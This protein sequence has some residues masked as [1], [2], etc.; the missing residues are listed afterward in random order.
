MATLKSL[1]ARIAKLQ[2]QARTMMRKQSATV[3]AQIHSLMHEHGLTMED[4]GAKFRA[5][6][7]GPEAATK[8]V[9][10][11][12]GAVAK[13]MD[14]KTGATWSGHGRAPA[15]IASA[16]NRDRFLVD[17]ASGNAPAVTKKAVKQDNY[18][19]GVQPSKYRDPKTGA[20][21]SGRGKAPGWLADAKDRSKFLIATVHT[22][23]AKGK[24]A[25]VETAAKKVASKKGASTVAMKSGRAASNAASRKSSAK[26]AGSNALAAKKVDS[27]LEKKATAPASSEGLSTSA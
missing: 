6:R 8:S 1:Q 25:T 7:P 26:R 12:S 24:L 20:E 2:S 4:I 9:I 11:K 19:R 16:R 14:P 23:T 10:G 22:L 27:K 21:W 3:I 17:G 13:Y 15:W 18:V 5:K